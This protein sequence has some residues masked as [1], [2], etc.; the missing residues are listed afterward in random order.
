MSDNDT[1]RC[2]NCGRRFHIDALDS[3]PSSFP[4]R[5]VEHQLARLDEAADRGEDFDRLECA[6]CYGPGYEATP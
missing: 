1:A 5:P 3:K 4:R 6:D 2:A